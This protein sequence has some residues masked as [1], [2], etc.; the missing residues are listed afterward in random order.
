MRIA[1]FRSLTLVSALCSLAAAGCVDRDAL[2]DALTAT[3]GEAVEVSLGGLFSSG[4]WSEPGD[5]VYVG[6]T[7][8]G[9]CV[10]YPYAAHEEGVAGLMLSVHE[11]DGLQVG[12]GPLS[13]RSIGEITE[14]VGES[15][16]TWQADV[17][18]DIAGAGTTTVELVR[19]GEVVDA[20]QVETVTWERAED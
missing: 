12:E 8:E 15:G 11:F 14:Q 6:C 5:S 16:S 4:V 13:L 9:A 1:S 20:M 10:T 17:T 3:L 19:D 2:G 18:F 7:A